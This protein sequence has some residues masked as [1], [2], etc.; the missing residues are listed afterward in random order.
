MNL[1]NETAQNVLECACKAFAEKGYS[2]TSISDICGMADAN[3]A[4]VNY[5][6]RSKQGLYEV[7]FNHAWECFCQKYPINLE[8]CGSAEDKLYKFINSVIY[9]IFDPE[10]AGW[11]M[12]LMF[13]EAVNPSVAIHHILVSHIKTVRNKLD[14]IIVELTGEDNMEIIYLLNM[15]IMG[16]CLFFNM[17]RNI[18]KFKLENN[19][20]PF[21]RPEF[22]TVNKLSDLV[23][24]TY[25]FCLNALLSFRKH[26]E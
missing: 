6:F 25:K 10:Q 26:G 7:V 5:Y 15:S 21:N 2:D 9:G 20:P 4:A 23:D 24:H 19:I 14:S 12:Q 11:F 16:N 22:R 8:D 17:T 18:R 13:H 3:R 1:P